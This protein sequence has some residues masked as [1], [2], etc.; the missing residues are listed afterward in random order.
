M[1]DI[2]QILIS[3][4]L[5]G[6]IY[7][8]GALGLTVCFGVLNVLN[9]AHGEFLMLGAF[10][11]YLAFN[12]FGINPFISIIFLFWVFFIVGC[13]FEKFLIRPISNRTFH[14]MLIASTLVTFGVAIAIEDFVAFIW[15]GAEAGISYELPTIMVAGI[16]ISML[17]LV[18][19]VFIITLTILFHVFMKSTY[20]GKA[21]RGI[22][23]NRRGAMVIGINIG[24]ISTITFGIGTALAA[25]SGVI[26]AT[27]YTFSPF[28][29]LPLTVNFLAIIVLGGVGS[30]GGALAG[31]MILGIT[32][33]LVGYSF[34]L[35]WSP[36]VAFLL[37]ILIL[38]FRPKG[39]FTT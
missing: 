26:Y 39:I 27:I 32:E 7:A 13:L 23:Q 17:R 25:I 16:H 21:L 19:L 1:I 38:I 24:K 2:F 37:L 36:V 18:A 14:E 6:G 15:G 3:G 35:E 9:V 12:Y 4:L 22:A 33:C 30:F 29:G 28:I 20:I 10:L 31:G 5:L 34:G 8:L 11:G